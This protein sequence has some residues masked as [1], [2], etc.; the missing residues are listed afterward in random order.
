MIVEI[1]FTWRTGVAVDCNHR[2]GKAGAS[3]SRVD[4]AAAV[5]PVPQV[6]HGSMCYLSLLTLSSS[7]VHTVLA[8]LVSVEAAQVMGLWLSSDDCRGRLF[9]TMFRPFDTRHMGKKLVVSRLR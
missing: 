5:A 9:K 1:H 8:L 2:L 7:V 4:T 3:N 6:T